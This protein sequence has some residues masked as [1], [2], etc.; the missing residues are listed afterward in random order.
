MLRNLGNLGCN[1]NDYLASYTSLTYFHRIETT[2]PRFE[3]EIQCVLGTSSSNKSQS[4]HIQLCFT[5]SKHVPTMSTQSFRWRTI[6]EVAIIS[7]VIYIFIGTPGL[8]DSLRGKSSNEEPVSIGR[9]KPESLVYPNSDL[10]CPRH[11]FDAHVFSTEPLIIYLDGFLSDREAGHL[12][13]IRYA[14]EVIP[15]T[16]LA[17]S[18]VVQ[19]S[20]RSRPSSIK[21]RRLR[22]SLSESRRRPLLIGTQWCNALSSELCPF[23]AGLLIRLSSDCGH[24]CVANTAF[25]LRHMTQ[26]W[27]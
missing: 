10:T 12:V 7:T 25:T 27:S 9:A 23:K 24:R 8:P 15:S 5:A 19:I 22:M 4:H 6:V 26:K 21:G 1:P 13:D 2:L 14:Q 11:D 18:E 16:S 20:G 17:D 3:V